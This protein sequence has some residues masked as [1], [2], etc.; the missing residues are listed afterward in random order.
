MEAILALKAW[1][2][3]TIPGAIG[4]ALSL[5][6][7]KEKTQQMSKLELVCVFIFGIALAHY[8]GGAAIEYSKLDASGLIADAIKLTVGLLGMATLTNVMSQLP[9]AIAG[10]RKKWTGE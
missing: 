10:L 7:N 4:S 8:L 2:S 5:Y 3:T 1:L 9:L 6:V